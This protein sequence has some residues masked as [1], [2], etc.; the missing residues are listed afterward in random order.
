MKTLPRKRPYLL[1]FFNW[2]KKIYEYLI[3]RNVYNFENHK[4]AKSLHPNAH[5]LL[6][7][8]TLVFCFTK[9][10]LTSYIA[11]TKT[12]NGIWWQPYLVHSSLFQMKEF[13][14]SCLGMGGPSCN[15]AEL[16]AFRKSAPKK[17]THASQR[18][19]RSWNHSQS[20]DMLPKYCTVHIMRD[21]N[22][23]SDFKYFFFFVVLVTS[24]FIRSDNKNSIRFFA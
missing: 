11:K 12:Q 1:I 5:P 4:S 24:I 8:V 3:G 7:Y 15:A 9:E 23:V 6:S 19:A 16:S 2:T 18:S 17:S 20:S 14:Q 21:K 13:L 10:R 22:H